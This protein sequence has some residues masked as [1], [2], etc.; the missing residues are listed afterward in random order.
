MFPIAQLSILD[1]CISVYSY[2]VYLFTINKR[3][4]GRSNGAIQNVIEVLVRCD[5]FGVMSTG[6]Q[7]QRQ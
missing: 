5:D 1:V 4:V 3:G 6:V 2:A 7:L